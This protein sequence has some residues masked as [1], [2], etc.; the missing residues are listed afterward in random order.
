[1][2]RGD[3]HTPCNIYCGRFEGSLLP[4]NFVLPDFACVG[5]RQHVRGVRLTG[6][7][8]FP[9]VLHAL[10]RG[11]LRCEPALSPRGIPGKRLADLLNCRVQNLWTV[12]RIVSL[13]NLLTHRADKSGLPCWRRESN[14][15]DIIHTSGNMTWQ[16]L[17]R[18][19]DLSARARRARV[20]GPDRR[21]RSIGVDG[22]SEGLARS[23]SFDNHIALPSASYL[24]WLEYKRASGA[25]SSGPRGSLTLR[26]RADDI[27]R[28]RKLTGES[29]CRRIFPT[30]VDHPRAIDF[31]RIC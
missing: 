31:G 22:W 30:R 4:R 7:G 16:V 13:A 11:K 9:R 29:A 27:E 8:S 28:P 6:S 2:G 15:P 25:P 1:L 21:Q 12:G 24:T 19:T 20:N 18:A 17:D 14:R 23:L 5:H 3:K 10:F 26:I